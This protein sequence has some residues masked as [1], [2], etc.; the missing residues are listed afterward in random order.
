MAGWPFGELALNPKCLVFSGGM[1]WAYMY[2]PCR[3]DRH[4]RFS[5]ALI[6]LG[7]YVG[8]AWYDAMY[9]CSVK[10]RQGITGAL[11]G[12]LKPAAV[13]GVYGG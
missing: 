1:V 9:G 11:T 13:G 3:F 12:P 4:W 10:M 6:A 8:L 7:S 2:L 5:V